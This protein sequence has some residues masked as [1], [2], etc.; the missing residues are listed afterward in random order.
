MPCASSHEAVAFRRPPLGSH[1]GMNHWYSTQPLLAWC[2]NRY[3]FGDVHYTYVAMPFHPYRLANPPSSR[4]ME[5]Y[6]RLFEGAQDRDIFNDSIR[7]RRPGL[8]DGVTYNSGK[9]A[10]MVVVQLHDI[11]DNVDPIFFTPLVLR[12]DLDNLPDERVDA[13]AGS[14]AHGMNSSERLITD[15]APGEF[16]VILVSDNAPHLFT[17]AGVALVISPLTAPDLPAPPPAEVLTILAGR[18]F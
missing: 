8:H 14:R 10:P 18:C 15:L 3:F 9:L 4:P 6:E 13:N 5:L 1:T 17:D 16:D 7:G 2:L 11:I 12:V